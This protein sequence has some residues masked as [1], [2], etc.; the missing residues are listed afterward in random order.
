MENDR[1]NG[2]YLCAGDTLSMQDVVKSLEQ[3]GY[4]DGY[5][6]PRL[7]LTGPIGTFV[8]KLLSYTQ[9]KGTG[10][11]LRTHLGKSVRYD[12]S[13]IRNELGVRFRPARESLLAA[14]DDLGRWGYLTANG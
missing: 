1:A 14:V 4:R 9:P 8:I 12:N 10:S 6:L 2:R 5:K 7:D 11:Y 13:K 3:A